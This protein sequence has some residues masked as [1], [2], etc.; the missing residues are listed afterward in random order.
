M[1][2]YIHYGHTK[3]HKG[4][5]KPIKNTE[6]WTKPN[7]GLWASPVDTKYGWKDWCHSNEFR[8]CKED[9]MFK[10]ILSENSKVL[11][12]YSINDLK[13]LP[14]CFSDK[15]YDTRMVYLD[16]EILSSE[17]DAIELHLSEEKYESFMDSLYYKL[18]GWDCDSILIMNPDI[19]CEIQRTS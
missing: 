18:Y 2:E 5:F 9:N 7:G 19:I 13:D 3:F 17:Y 6:F 16:F 4:C 12:L 15:F 10:F 8:E 11:H 14:I 1:K